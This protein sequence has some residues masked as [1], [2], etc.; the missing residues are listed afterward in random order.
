MENIKGAQLKFS[1]VTGVR[2]GQ[3]DQKKTNDV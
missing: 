2:S 3:K 1:N